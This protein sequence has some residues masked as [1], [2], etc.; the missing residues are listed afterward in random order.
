MVYLFELESK[1]Q[2]QEYK[3]SDSSSLKKFMH[4]ASVVDVM[5]TVFW[6]GECIGTILID[7]Q[8]KVKRKLFM[9]NIMNK[10][11]ERNE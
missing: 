5:T 11:W 3:H 9:D 4:A 2:T 8:E 6:Q 1:I 10:N 7:Y